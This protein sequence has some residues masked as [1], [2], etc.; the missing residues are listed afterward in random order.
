MKGVI[1]NQFF[2]EFDVIIHLS[3]KDDPIAA[4]GV[5]H[6][7]PPG[8]GE[9]NNAESIVPKSSE[10]GERY[11]NSLSIRTTMTLACDH[12]FEL[13]VVPPLAKHACDSAH[14]TSVRLGFG[15]G[16]RSRCE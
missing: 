16:R 12:G 7:L 4:R 15:G 10:T 9:V 8:L 13:V 2:P 5:T 14:F 1:R 11:M 6:R 3:V